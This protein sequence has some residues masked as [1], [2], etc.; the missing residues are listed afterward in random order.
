MRPEQELFRKNRLSASAE[1]RGTEKQPR[2]IRKLTFTRSSLDVHVC[3]CLPA[4]MTKQCSQKL[5]HLVSCS[6]INLG[7][8]ETSNST[9]PF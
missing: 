1:K 6:V 7:R 2:F 8:T 5:A 4:G 3:L 9:I